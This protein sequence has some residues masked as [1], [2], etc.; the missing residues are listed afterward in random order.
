MDF[1]VN[2]PKEFLLHLVNDALEHPIL[3]GKSLILGLFKHVKFDF[4]Q[5]RGEDCSLGTFFVQVIL[6]LG[7]T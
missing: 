2:K 4:K 3:L 1:F 7:I 6:A 5:P